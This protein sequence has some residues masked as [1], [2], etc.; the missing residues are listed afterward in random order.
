M[1]QTQTATQPKYV[2]SFSNGQITVPKEFRDSLGLGTDFWLRM[3]IHEGG[4]VSQPVKDGFDTSAYVESINSIDSSGF[5]KKDFSNWK[6]IRKEF[7]SRVKR[8][9]W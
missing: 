3:F 4:I 2:K 1:L 8:Y 5:T 6:S 7:D 9:D